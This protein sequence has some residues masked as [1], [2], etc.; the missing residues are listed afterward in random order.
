MK[1]DC[2]IFERVTVGKLK[3][4]AVDSLIHRVWIAKFNRVATTGPIGNGEVTTTDP[5]HHPLSLS[6]KI[7]S[8]VTYWWLARVVA[9]YWT[10]SARSYIWK[11]V[12]ATMVSVTAHRLANW[13]STIRVVDRV[14]QRKTTGPCVLTVKTSATLTILAIPTERSIRKI[15]VRVAIWIILNRGA[16]ILTTNRRS[17][18]TGWRRL[19]M[20]V[21]CSSMSS[22][23]RIK[24]HFNSD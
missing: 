11:F 14:H 18:L 2:V 22:T 6:I 19:L 15:L 8:F 20:T 1:T 17:S 13:P 5:S 24:I 4:S 12:S 3:F 9:T 10:M 7:E 16:S 23:P 21:R